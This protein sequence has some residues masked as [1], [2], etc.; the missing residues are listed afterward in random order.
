MVTTKILIKPHLAEYVKSKYETNNG[1]VSFPKNDDL[2]HLVWQ[3][4]TKTPANVN[5]FDR[6]GNLIIAL[7]DRR[8]GKNPEVYNYI[9]ARGEKIIEKKIRQLFTL[10]LHTA[11]ENNAFSGFVLTNQERVSLFMAQYS[12][13]S[14]SEDALLKDYYRWRDLVRKKEK[15]QYRKKTEKTHTT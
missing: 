5:P 6:S 12:L 14:I 10:E 2:Y 7:P 3:L 13:E 9:S 4:M 8:V 1:C 11:M 15:R